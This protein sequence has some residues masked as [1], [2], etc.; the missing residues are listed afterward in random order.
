MHLEMH[1]KTNNLSKIGA[2]KNNSGLYRL[3]NLMK[4]VIKILKL[5]HYECPNLLNIQCVKI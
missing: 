3:Q 2:S 4:D 1:V 5:K